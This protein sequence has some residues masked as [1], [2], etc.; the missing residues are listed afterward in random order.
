MDKRKIE[1]L[2]KVSKDVIR[3]CSLANGAIVAAIPGNS[4]YP[5]GVQDYGYVWVRD[6]AYVCTAAD[7][8]GLKDIPEKFFDWCLNKAEDFKKTGLFCNAYHIN[9][10]IHGTL[11]SGKDVKVP[12]KT[13]ER[14]LHMIHHAT[15]FQPDQNGALLIAIAH[16]IRHFA[17]K[18]SF[19]FKELTDKTASGICSSW[20]EGRFRLPYFD[21]WEERCILPTQKRHHTY[22]LAMCIRGLRLA[23]EMLGK[24]KSWLRTEQ[25][26]SSAFHDIYRSNAKTIPRTYT[27]QRKLKESSLARHDLLP[28]TSLLGVVYP[29]EMLDASDGKIRR[30]VEQIIRKNTTDN[31]GLLRYPSDKY[32]GGV[33]QGWV[34]LSGA[35]AWPLLSFWMAIYFCLANDKKRALKHF[36]W[37]IRR[38]DRY[39]PEQIFKDRTK[40]A[41]SPLAWSHAMFIIAAKHL[42]L[43]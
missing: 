28:D 31:G 40:R 5:P 37:P 9:G 21:L 32:C 16:H 34:S 17:I 18:D 29:S 38:V 4:E 1:K 20:K 24:R 42:Q 30:T 12:Q 13:R 43:I 14:Y 6:A 33:R 15:Q 23:M 41:I 3:D 22:S 25:E 7:L 2:V 8:V 27:A 10:T 39:I 26:M 11:V 36:Y 19:R 35:G